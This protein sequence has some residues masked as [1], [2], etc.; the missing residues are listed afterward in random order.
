MSLSRR[1]VLIVT[2]LF[3][4]Y[5][6][7]M[8]FAV[9]SEI[10]REPQAWMGTG[11]PDAVFGWLFITGVG[12]GLAGL[13]GLFAILAGLV[14]L[15]RRTAALWL[16]VIPGI[17]GLIA[18]I[19]SVAIVCLLHGDWQAY[20]PPV[21]IGLGIPPLAAFLTGRAIRRPQP[22][23]APAGAPSVTEEAGAQTS[24]KDTENSATGE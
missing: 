13:V 21:A 15:Q 8:G 9:G 2:G 12:G 19:A 22:A 4:L 10:I 3:G 18:A 7:L 11:D 24:G 20:L 23:A 1:L 17:L 5:V 6:A 14:G 16:L